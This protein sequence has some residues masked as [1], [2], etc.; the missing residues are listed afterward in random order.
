MKNF[1]I[2]WIVITGIVFFLILSVYG[3]KDSFFTNKISPVVSTQKVSESTGTQKHVPII[4][5]K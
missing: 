4:F 2:S 5:H 3:V 1:K